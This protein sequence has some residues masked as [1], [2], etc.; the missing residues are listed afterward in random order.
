[1][2]IK[3]L[4][5][6]FFVKHRTIQKKK[7]LDTKWHLEAKNYMTQSCTHDK[8]LTYSPTYYHYKQ[9]GMELTDYVKQAHLGNSLK[10]LLI[11]L[12]A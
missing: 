2:G 11:Q 7:H 6:A 9:P 10:F 5:P 1:M 12:E 3:I 8:K 4:N